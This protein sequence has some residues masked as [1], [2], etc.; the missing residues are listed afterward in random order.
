MEQKSQNF[1]FQ[2]ISDLKNIIKISHEKTSEVSVVL[3]VF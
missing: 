2:I 1:S 3:P